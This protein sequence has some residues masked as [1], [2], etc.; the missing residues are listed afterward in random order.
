MYSMTFSAADSYN[1]FDSTVIIGYFCQ[2]DET[3]FIWAVAGNHVGAV[4]V[5]LEAGADIQAK[6]GASKR[7]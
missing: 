7:I 2:G 6:Y 4:E 5:L 3:P 1:I